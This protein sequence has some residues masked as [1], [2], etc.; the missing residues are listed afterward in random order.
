MI[1]AAFSMQSCRLWLYVFF[2][3]IM[4][5]LV[6]DVIFTHTTVVMDGLFVSI[7]T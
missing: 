3:N 1:H 5:S 7:T 6:C 2:N 4:Y